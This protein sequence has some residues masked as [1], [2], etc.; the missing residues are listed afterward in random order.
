MSHTPTPTPGLVW[1]PIIS[2]LLCWSPLPPDWFRCLQPDWVFPEL[3]FD[4]VPYQSSQTNSSSFIYTQCPSSPAPDH[5]ASQLHA[6]FIAASHGSCSCTNASRL[7]KPLP[8]LIF[9]QEW[10]TLW[11]GQIP[12]KMLQNSVQPVSWL[13]VIF[14]PRLTIS[15]ECPLCV[16][17]VSPFMTLTVALSCCQRFAASAFTKELGGPGKAV[18]Y[19]YSIFQETSTE[20]KSVHPWSL[21][22]SLAHRQGRNQHRCVEGTRM[23]HQ[24]TKFKFHFNWVLVLHTHLPTK[25]FMIVVQWNSQNS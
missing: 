24:S 21:T 1:N 25:W 2:H 16:F 8:L 11:L 3:T 5:P 13:G 6:T 15:F 18:P 22:H 20:N 14:R 10:V 19:V 9:C 7:V 23:D 17:P 4:I 12:L